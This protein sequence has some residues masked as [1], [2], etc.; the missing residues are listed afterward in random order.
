MEGPRRRL[1]NADEYRRWRAR[2]RRDGAD[3]VYF[4]NFTLRPFRDEAW[5]A[6]LGDEATPTVIH[7]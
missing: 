5:R 4:F 2:V 3:G 7:H 6:M 1:L